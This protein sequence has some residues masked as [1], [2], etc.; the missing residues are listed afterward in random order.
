MEDMSFT[1]IEIAWALS[2]FTVGVD[3]PEWVK[4][5]WKEKWSVNKLSKNL[6]EAQVT[7]KVL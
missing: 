3:D 7:K 2:M 4:L 6:K 1:E 5:L